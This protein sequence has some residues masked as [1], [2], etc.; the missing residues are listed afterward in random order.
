MKLE[1]YIKNLPTDLQGK[2]RACGSVDELLALAREHRVAL[3]DEV[4]E[5]V[6]GAD[7]PDPENCR[8]ARC[9]RCGS[10]NITFIDASYYYCYDCGY[11]WL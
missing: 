4:L 11:T 5:A 1:D 10:T 9:P 2:A 3:P 6:A 7:G 8:P